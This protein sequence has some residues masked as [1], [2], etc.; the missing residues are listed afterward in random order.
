[1]KLSHHCSHLGM[2]L[3]HE[4]HGRGHNRYGADQRGAR[5][6][7]VWAQAAVE[8]HGPGA[9]RGTRIWPSFPGLEPTPLQSASMR[10]FEQPRNTCGGVTSCEP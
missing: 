8:E 6:R 9:P 5:R 2:R 10:G 3:H 1:M 4:E 7:F